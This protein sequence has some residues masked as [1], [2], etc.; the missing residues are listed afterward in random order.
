[1]FF[2]FNAFNYSLSL[3]LQYILQ[4]NMY[5][6]NNWEIFKEEIKIKSLIYCV[7]FNKTLF[8]FTFKRA[9]ASGKFYVHGRVANIN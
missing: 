3:F 5:K 1:M 6:V 4:H 2:E 8:S 9:A 7:A